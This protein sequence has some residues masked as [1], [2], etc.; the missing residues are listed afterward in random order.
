MS[1]KSQNKRHLDSLRKLDSSNPKD[2]MAK[3]V[4]S[5]QPQP[6]EKPNVVEDA[7]RPR[8]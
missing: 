2:F 5:P 8:T 3:P 4:S 1:H 6:K 7:N